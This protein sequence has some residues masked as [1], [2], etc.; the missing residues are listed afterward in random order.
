MAYLIAFTLW[1]HNKSEII[2][3]RGLVYIRRDIYIVVQNGA[4]L[5]CGVKR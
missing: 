2:K 5:C 4:D 1:N 3:Q